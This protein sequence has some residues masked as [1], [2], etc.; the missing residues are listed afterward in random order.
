[1]ILRGATRIVDGLGAVLFVFVSVAVLVSMLAGTADVVS[2]R[3]LGRT[4]PGAVEFAQNLMPIIV[5]GALAYIQR[6]GQHIRVEFI[7][8]RLGARGRAVL[9]LLNSVVVA[10]ASAALAWI[11]WQGFLRSNA[12]KESGMAYPFPIYPVK[13]FIVVGLGIM[14]LKMVVE[15]F[16]SIDRIIHPIEQLGSIGRLLEETAGM[17]VQTDVASGG[18]AVDGAP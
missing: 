8:D 17:T 5:F 13:F 1:M 6:E 16:V 12:I 11:S 3:L 15:I 10:F 7:Y 2:I 18:S 9:D 4:V 14:I